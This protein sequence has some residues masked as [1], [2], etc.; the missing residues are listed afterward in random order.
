MDRRNSLLP[1]V[2][3][4]VTVALE[5]LGV[6][7]G[8]R[9]LRALPHDRSQVDADEVALSQRWRLTLATAAVIATEGMA[10]T[11]IERITREAGVSKNT[12][13]KFHDTKEDA[14][15]S[16][17]EAVDFVL[18]TLVSTD[19]LL[20]TEAE[21]EMLLSKVISTYLNLL[22][23]A[24]D[25]TRI[26]LVEALTASPRVRLRRAET[27]ERFAAAMQSAGDDLRGRGVPLRKLTDQQMIA[28][29]GGINEL[30]VVHITRH[31]VETLPDLQADIESFAFLILADHG[32]G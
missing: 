16:C 29:L 17:Y 31:P 13:Y 14:L 2:H 15:L 11:T 12:F 28:A 7:M 18:D 24:P 23:A 26:F 27:L 19:Q 1:A 4:L 21:V 8:D 22:A 20:S 10:G 9:P 5:R 25:L 6:H 30:C 3:P 32:L